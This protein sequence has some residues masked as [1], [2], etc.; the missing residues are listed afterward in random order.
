MRVAIPSVGYADTVGAIL[1]AWQKLIPFASFRVVTSL[2]DD[3]TARVAAELGAVVV[4]TDVWTKPVGGLENVRFNKAA[5]LDLALFHDGE[6]NHG[7]SLLS[8]DADVY[9]VGMWSGAY[10]ERNTIYSVPRYL[11]RTTDDLRAHVA[12]GAD[13]PLIHARHKGQSAP[14]TALGTTPREAVAQALACIG[15]FQLWRHSPGLHF[16]NSRTAGKYDIDFRNLFPHRACLPGLHVVHLGELDR[17]NWKGRR[18][19]PLWN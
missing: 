18:T 16:G 3:E 14:A 6:P 11:A 2:E 7:E 12:T 13:L 5:A 4:R 8:I 10:L 17:E 15:Y 19:L 1:P 9:P